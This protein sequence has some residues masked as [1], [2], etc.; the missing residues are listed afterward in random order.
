MVIRCLARS[1][2]RVAN[3]PPELNAQWANPVCSLVSLIGIDDNGCMANI[4]ED[5]DKSA[6]WIANALNSSGYRADFAP[7]SL[8]EID[9]FF[10]EHS[11]DGTAKPGGLL[12][13][14]LGQRIFALGSYIGEVARRELGG[15]WGGDDNDP[16]AEINVELLLP[17]GTR[18]WP[19]QR[20]MKRFK[21][22]EEDGIAAWGAGLG[23]AVG[24][25]PG[26]PQEPPRQGF[27]KRL[28]R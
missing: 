2:F 12:S 19:V 6:D 4:K 1:D 21:N 22:G 17:D 15:R 26:F 18:C 10:E 16:E 20:A 23:L 7:R 13:S 25:P 9:R 8:W 28:F 11:Q 14:G 3:C 27:F 5:I 24:A